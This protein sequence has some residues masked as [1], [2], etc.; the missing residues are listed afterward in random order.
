MIWFDLTW[1]SCSDPV[2]AALVPAESASPSSSKQP[3]ATSYNGWILYFQDSI[4]HNPF[5]NGEG[6]NDRRRHVW[7]E[8]RTAWRGSVELREFWRQRALQQNKNIKTI[9]PSEREHKR[10]RVDEGELAVSLLCGQEGATL[11]GY[12]GPRT[13]E[14]LCFVYV[15]Y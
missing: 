10:R 9:T 4:K 1:F 15:T 14:S 7:S 11:L 3:K 12:I 13:K 2:G 5:L 8:C 6:N